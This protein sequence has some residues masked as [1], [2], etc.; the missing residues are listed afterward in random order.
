MFLCC[1]SHSIR[2]KCGSWDTRRGVGGVVSGNNDVANEPDGELGGDGGVGW[3]KR[4]IPLC[5]YVPSLL[6]LTK[7][8][9]LLRSGLSTSGLQHVLMR[10]I[11]D[12]EL[13]PLTHWRVIF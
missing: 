13:T 8:P 4:V 12:E 11:N 10:L 1:R 6:R 2:W 5:P 7:N 9:L 3:L